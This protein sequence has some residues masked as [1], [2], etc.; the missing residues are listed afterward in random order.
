[1]GMACVC[2][3]LE[4]KILMDIQDTSDVGLKFHSRCMKMSEKKKMGIKCVSI[5]SMSRQTRVFIVLSSFHCESEIIII[6]NNT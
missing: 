5:H 4:T 1:M 3:P 6:H 2:V